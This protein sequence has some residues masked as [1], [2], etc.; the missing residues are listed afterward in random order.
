MPT[1]GTINVH[2]TLFSDAACT[3]PV[4]ISALC[5]A[6]KYAAELTATCPQNWSLRPLT[7]YVPAAGELYLLGTTGTCNGH[8]PTALAAGTKFYRAGAKVPASEF[9]GAEIKVEP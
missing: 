2:P 6:A 7:A 9:V 5:S 8:S 1:E 4:A 3:Q